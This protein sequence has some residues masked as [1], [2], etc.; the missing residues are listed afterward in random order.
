MIVADE[1]D[2]RMLNLTYVNLPK[3]NNYSAHIYLPITVTKWWDWNLNLT[4]VLAQQQLTLG[5]PIEYNKFAQATTTMTFKL[6]KKFYIDVYYWG[7]TRV[8]VSNAIVKAGHNMNVSLKKRVNDSWTFV[9]EAVNVIPPKQRLIFEQKDFYRS[10][11][12]DGNGSR[13]RIRLGATW[14]FKSGKAFNA[15]QVEKASDEN[16]M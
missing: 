10:I 1:T 3:L 2:P 6:P 14:S 13:L 12:T 9:C 4:G 16:R 15:K 7:M 11:N 8:K 5:A